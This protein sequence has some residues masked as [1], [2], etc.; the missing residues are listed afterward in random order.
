[1]YLSFGL[2]DFDHGMAVGSRCDVRRSFADV[3]FVIPLFIPKFIPMFARHGGSPM[4]CSF[5]MRCSFADV[6]A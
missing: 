5:L 3:M 4:R 6:I 2:N 1:M